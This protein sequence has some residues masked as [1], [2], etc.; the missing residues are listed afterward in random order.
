MCREI[1]APTIEPHIPNRLIV[2]ANLKSINFCF[3]KIIIEIIEV[4]IK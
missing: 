1:I 2:I 3:A 4:G